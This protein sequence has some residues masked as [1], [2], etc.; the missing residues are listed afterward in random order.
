MVSHK[1]VAIV[2]GGI[3]GLTVCYRLQ[4]AIQQ[5]HLPLEVILLESSDR[6]GGIIH[7]HHD[8]NLLVEH[9]PDSFI[10]NKPW[11]VELCDE[12]EM[13]EAYVGTTTAHRQ[14]FIVRHGAL[15]PVPKGLYLMVPG[16]LWPFATS[17]VMSWRG[18]LRM[19]LDLVL[20]RRTSTE[21]ES[22]AH[23]VR[24]RFGREALER[25]AQ[26]MVG[27][28]YTANPEHLSLQATMPQFLEMERRH[29]S[30]IRA[31]Q[32]R[33]RVASSQEASGPRYGLF[34]SFRD[35]MQTLVERLRSCIPDC[36]VRLRTEVSSVAFQPGSSH[37]RL[38]MRHAPAL[39]VD[40]VCLAL[41]APQASRLLCSADPELATDLQIPYASSAILNLAFKR[42]DIDH[43]LNGMG[44]VVPAI[45]K[46]TLLA[47]SFSSVKFDGRAPMDQ[48][49]LRAFVGGA[50]H[51]SEL[52]RSDAAIQQSV[53]QD[54]QQLLGITGDPIYAHL[55]RW[56]Q[57]MAQYHL[58]HIQRVTR[59]ED[60][61]R[62]LSGLALAGN[63]YHGVG[64]PDCIHSGNLAAQA[65]LDHLS[66]TAV[67]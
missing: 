57:S 23:F 63:A 55:Q 26:P 45:E 50:L 19:G 15:R 65:L 33:Q 48:V 9:G 60:R 30:L 38:H 53:C 13:S 5:D 66:P 64:I 39:D 56:P 37:W 52:D 20:P 4:R 40:A 32:H 35:G 31:M 62:R 3:T 17:S 10:T 59:I 49:L 24:R 21:D 2:G 58:G 46:R 28:I 61:V 42:S 25:V 44:F 43:P 16:S 7:T 22:L 6:L 54:L 67:P 18:K 8:H 27:G 1:R 47:C 41:P 29:G 11:A 36:R 12:L 14:S 34:L 51:Q